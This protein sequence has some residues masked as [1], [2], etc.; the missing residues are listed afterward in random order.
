M[1]NGGGGGGGGFHLV[2]PSFSC[3]K[4]KKF[5][6][7]TTQHTGVVILDNFLP[8]HWGNMD[9]FFYDKG[10]GHPEGKYGCYLGY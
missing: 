2:D 10:E 3:S 8:I 7:C 6:I 5:H 9:V 1:T 4:K